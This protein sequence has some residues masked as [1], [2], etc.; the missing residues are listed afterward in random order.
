MAIITT[1]RFMQSTRVKVEVEDETIIAVFPNLL[2]GL[3]IH[4]NQLKQSVN[5]IDLNPD[6]A[7]IAESN[8]AQPSTMRCH[9][10]GGT[11]MSFRLRQLTKMREKPL[12]FDQAI[13]IE[14]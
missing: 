2:A 3:A 5:R 8:I 12:L 6:M 9:L 14:S 10:T 4:H 1:L 13:F 11:H 7:P